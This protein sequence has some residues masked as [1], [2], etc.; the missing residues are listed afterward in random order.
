MLNNDRISC[1]LILILYLRDCFKDLFI[2][3]NSFKT[4]NYR[5]TLLF[6][7]LLAWNQSVINRLANLNI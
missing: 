1:L 4:V 2:V 6:V 7:L 3:N 5:F